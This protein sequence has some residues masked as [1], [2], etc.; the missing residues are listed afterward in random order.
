M[1]LIWL[2]VKRIVREK[3]IYETI[4]VM[5]LLMVLIN[6]MR[7]HETVAIGVIDLDQSNASMT[8]YEDTREVKFVSI[9]EDNLAY[10]FSKRN[11]VAAMVIPEA[12]QSDMNQ[13]IQIKHLDYFNPS[14]LNTLIAQRISNLKTG[15]TNNNQRDIIIEDIEQVDYKGMNTAIRS[16]GILL[17]SV[18]TMSVILINLL[19]WDILKNRI[20]RVLVSPIKQGRFLFEQLLSYGCIVFLMISVYFIVN[21]YFMGANYGESLWLIFV[22]LVMFTL[23]ALLLPFLIVCSAYDNQQIYALM[24]IYVMII[25]Y[26]GGCFF[27]LQYMP[28]YFQF[29]GKFTPTYW[30]MAGVKE[31]I[32]DGTIS[33][34][35]FEIGSLFVVVI[36]LF[37]IASKRRIKPVAG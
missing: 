12:F 27:P 8:L 24:R 21:I 35:M 28:D 26:L 13:E 5:M 23:F 31:V 4:F 1:K 29:V 2:Q 37:V 19:R 18:L 36:T 9:S 3:S 25:V 32:I 34:S 15:N 7:S 6:S 30:T 33:N 20:Q 22:L 17:Y 14:V 10:E 16:V 11:I